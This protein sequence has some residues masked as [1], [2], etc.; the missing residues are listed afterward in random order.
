MQ[1]LSTGAA[2]RRFETTIHYFYYN[3]SS[4]FVKEELGR[5][6]QKLQGHAARMSACAS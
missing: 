5:L 3:K 6:A 2:A 1:R 4:Q